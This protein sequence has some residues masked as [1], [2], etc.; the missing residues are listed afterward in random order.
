MKFYLQRVGR[1]RQLFQ[2]PTYRPTHAKVNS[3]WIKDLHVRDKTIT[4]IEEN[5]DLG[6]DKCALDITQEVWATKENS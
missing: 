4:L 3:K 6:F 2:R 1:K 5:Y